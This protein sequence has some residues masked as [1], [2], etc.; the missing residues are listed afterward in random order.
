M[1]L[2]TGTI[3]EVHFHLPKVMLTELSRQP[4]E[5]HQRLGGLGAKRTDQRVECSLASSVAVLPN[6]SQN[7]QR[8]QW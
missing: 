3:E 2:L 5:P 7:L 8:G 4:L 6:S 1:H